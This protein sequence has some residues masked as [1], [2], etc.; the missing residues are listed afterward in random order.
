[1]RKSE[2]ATLVVREI[3]PLG[4]KNAALSAYQ[5]E[6]KRSISLAVDETDN[7]LNDRRSF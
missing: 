5:S 6:C 3:I 7:Q 1:M 2:E 4:L